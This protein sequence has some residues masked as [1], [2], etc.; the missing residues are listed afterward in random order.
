[1]NRVRVI[2]SLANEFGLAHM[3]HMGRPS[4]C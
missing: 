3:E 4:A 1:V 2:V